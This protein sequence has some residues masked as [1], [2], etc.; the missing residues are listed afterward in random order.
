VDRAGWPVLAEKYIRSVSGCSA[1]GVVQAAEDRGDVHHTCLRHILLDR[2]GDL[3]VQPL[4][5]PVMVKEDHVRR[6]HALQVT[7]V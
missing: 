5:W 7:L 4:V 1:I 6:Q 2:I 3:L